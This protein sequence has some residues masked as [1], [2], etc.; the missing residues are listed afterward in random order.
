MIQK[1]ITISQQVLLVIDRPM[2]GGWV[3]SYI[4]LFTGYCLRHLAMR[5]RLV[6][7]SLT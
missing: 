5:C 4:N 7:K 6:K 2:H 1:K 3:A